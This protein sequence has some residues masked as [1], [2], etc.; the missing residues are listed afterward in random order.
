MGF[1][2]F[3]SNSYCVGGRHR[4]AKKNIFADITSKGSKVLYGYCSVRIRKKSMTVSDNTIK[5]EGL[6]D[7]FKNLV[8]K[9]LTHQKRWLKTY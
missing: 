9:D 6:G 5:A 2:K 8:E 7:F 4:S 3:E 1:Q